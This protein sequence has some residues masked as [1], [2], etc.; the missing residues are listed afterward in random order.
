MFGL[1]E[2]GEAFDDFENGEPG[3]WD[4]YGIPDNETH[5]MIRVTGKRNTDYRTMKHL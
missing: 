5:F 4:T 2:Q 3:P 1:K